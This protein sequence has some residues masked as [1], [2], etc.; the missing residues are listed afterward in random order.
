MM[1]FQHAADM[2]AQVFFVFRQANLLSSAV[3]MGRQIGNVDCVV[4]RSDL[5]HRI[6]GFKLSAFEH[7]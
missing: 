6:E 1:Q 5:V 2:T 4:E 7:K 3:D